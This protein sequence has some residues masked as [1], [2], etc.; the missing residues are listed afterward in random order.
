[1]FDALRERCL[2]TMARQILASAEPT[3]VDL[4]ALHSRGETA[5]AT[6]GVE[7]ELRSPEQVEGRALDLRSDL[8]PVAVLLYRGLTGAWPFSGRTDG[9]LAVAITRRPHR[10]VSLA[11]PHL[12]RAFDAF[13]AKALKKDAADR[14]PSA[15]SLLE[16]FRASVEASEAHQAPAPLT[17]SRP[18]VTQGPAPPPS[19]PP[20]D[21]APSPS[22][23]GASGRPYLLGLGLI[24]LIGVAVFVV[25]FL[26]SPR[27]AT[28]PEETEVPPAAAPRSNRIPAV[29]LPG[30]QQ[31][32]LP[33]AQPFILNV[34]L[35]RCADCMPV[36]DAWNRLA[37][38]NQVPKVQVVNVSAYK[39]ADEGWAE[40]YRVDDRLVWD[41]GP[42]LIAPLGISR[43][44][45]FVVRP[46]G[47]I[48]F[49]GH[50]DQKGF[51][52]ALER[53]VADAQR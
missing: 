44:T 30:K 39:P 41:R 14:Y 13:F 34:W 51:A 4:A 7:L 25:P 2:S 43:F 48:T 46:D 33:L 52:E 36:F 50:A 12:G 37:E 49:R 27:E 10:P 21:P 23:S 20:G 1:M 8:W 45:T 29:T 28:L 17:L 5:A 24:A 19:P 32:T 47:T 26:Y 38:A 31:I 53:A 9:E 6:A 16:A 18:H 40:R 15:P 42:A 22:S 35:E 11:A 3:L